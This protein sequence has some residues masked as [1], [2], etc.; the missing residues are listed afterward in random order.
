MAENEIAKIFND[1]RKQVQIEYIQN[2]FGTLQRDLNNNSIQLEDNEND[3]KVKKESIGQME[4]DNQNEAMNIMYIIKDLLKDIQSAQRRMLDYNG[5]SI[6]KID[7]I[8]Q[9]VKQ[10]IDVFVMNNADKANEILQEDNEEFKSWLLSE[11]EEYLNAEKLA[12]NK[13]ETQKNPRQEFANKLN[14]NIIS[15]EEQ[16]DFAKKANEDKASEGNEMVEAL[17]DDLII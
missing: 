14:A 15:Q 8:D 13:E 17:P 10:F 4:L 7:N 16:K 6:D 12:N 11:Y 2:F 1:K 5:Y 9:K 3:E